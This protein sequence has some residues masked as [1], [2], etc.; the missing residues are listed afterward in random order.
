[1]KQ[2]SFT[3]LNYPREINAT[4]YNTVSENLDISSR[5]SSTSS[6]N[7]IKTGNIKN[8]RKRSKRSSTEDYCNNS[9]CST[10]SEEESLVNNYVVGVVGA[11]LSSSSI[12]ITSFS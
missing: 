2:S 4:C 6:I 8:S 1:M 5:E 3:L 7:N 11:L 12:S 10:V 9:L